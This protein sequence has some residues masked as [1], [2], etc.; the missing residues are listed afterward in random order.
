M[1]RDTG[2]ETIFGRKEE[3]VIMIGGIEDLVGWKSFN[4]LI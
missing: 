2:R 1:S 4:V 3:I